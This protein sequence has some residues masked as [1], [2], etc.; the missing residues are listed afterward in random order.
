MNLQNEVDL[1]I[2]KNVAFNTDQ[3]DSM[4]IL[5]FNIQKGGYRRKDI[6]IEIN[7]DGS[8]ITIS[9]ENPN[10]SFHKTFI[11]PE[12]VVLDKIK[13]RFDQQQSRLTIRMPKLVKGMMNGI[14]IQE[15]KEPH[16]PDQQS[17]NV[18]EEIRQGDPKEKMNT[19]TTTTIIAGSTLLVSLIVVIFSFISSKNK[20]SKK[21]D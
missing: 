4:F 15:F 6:N 3:T 13:A 10:S 8:R 1:S 17:H 18:D 21:T 2:S 9:G 7:E 5:T 19:S 14:G 12:G 16:V 20:S 11:I